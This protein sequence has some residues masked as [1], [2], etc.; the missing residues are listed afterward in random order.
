MNFLDVFIA[1]ALTGSID[2]VKS[3][4]EGDP[5]LKLAIINDKN[6]KR[7]AWEHCARPNK[8]TCQQPFSV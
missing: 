7:N 4:T 2:C 5:T 8:K 1:H 3:N 6:G